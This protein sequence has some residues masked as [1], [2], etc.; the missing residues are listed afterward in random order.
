[1][2]YKL[3]RDLGSI[4]SKMVDDDDEC[5][6]AFVDVDVTFEDDF[7]VAVRLINSSFPVMHKN[8]GEKCQKMSK[9][10]SKN[11]MITI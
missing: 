2:P 5:D 6:A 10:N 7:L 3:G 1:M 8:H 9:L 11:K 4:N